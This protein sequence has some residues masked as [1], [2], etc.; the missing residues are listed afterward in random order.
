MSRVDYC[1]LLLAGA[2]KSV[3]NKLQLVMNAAVR[4]VSGTKKYN[5]GLTHLLHSELHCISVLN[6][7]VLLLI[8]YHVYIL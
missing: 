6:E 5:H 2:P 8:N 3:S 1:N 7:T 4:V